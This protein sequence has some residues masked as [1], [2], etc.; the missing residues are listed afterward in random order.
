MLIFHTTWKTW[1]WA[2]LAPKPQGKIFFQ[3]FQH[4][5]F[6]LYIYR[7]MFATTCQGMMCMFQPGAVCLCNPK[8]IHI[9]WL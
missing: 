4:R 9:F 6:A 1:F 3:K 7:D 2:I 5:D 8:R